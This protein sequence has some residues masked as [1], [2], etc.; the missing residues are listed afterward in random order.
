MNKY[1]YL[2]NQPIDRTKWDN[3]MSSLTSNAY[4][5]PEQNSINILPG[6]L[7]GDIYDPYGNKEENMGGIGVIV[8]HEITH[9]IDNLGSEYDDL[10]RRSNWWDSKDKETF[11]RKTDVLKNYYSALSPYPGALNYDGNS[12]QGEAMAD[13]GGLKGM[14]GIAAKNP[15]FDYD[16][17]FRAFARSWC[18][19]YSYGLAL[20]NAKDVHPMDFLR[21]NV[22]LQQFDKFNETYDISEGDGMYLPEEKRVIVW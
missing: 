7:A 13:M 22:V 16:L 2:V 4:F 1:Q 21:V 6:I 18:S 11:S 9:S 14:L 3:E 15:D 8:G 19:K 17:F 10:G 12:V 5:N 20:S